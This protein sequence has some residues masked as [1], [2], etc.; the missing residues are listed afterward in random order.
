MIN[1][2]ETK[3]KIIK[4]L[5]EKGPSLPLNISHHIEMSPVFASA[6]LSELVN[7]REVRLSHMKI[8]SSPLYLIPGQEQKLESFA[9]LN[10]TGWEKSAF[11]K[12]KQ[13]KILK[14]EKQ[15]PALRVAL[16]NIKDFAVAFRFQDKI[17]WKYAFVSEQEARD[18]L[19]KKP[20]KKPE[21]AALLKIKKQVKK[22]LQKPG[23]FFQQ[24]KDFLF[25]KDIEFLEEIQITKKEVMG[26]ARVNSDLGKICFL[27]IAKDKKRANIAD[28]TM[29]YQKAIQAK[30][31]CLFLSKGE[32][33]S[34]T[35]E[36][37]EEHKNLVKIGK[38]T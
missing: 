21:K 3:Q 16:R 9:E 37:I 8:G 34:T 1:M 38:I 4:I 35:K 13:N 23:K 32:P 36:F 7:E 10:L 27:L 5:N 19:M 31:P 12:L 2:H 18:L 17:M 11:L 22:P 33:A 6:I 25:S 26:K 28:L 29:A 24:V 14:D 20:R 30:L 15:E